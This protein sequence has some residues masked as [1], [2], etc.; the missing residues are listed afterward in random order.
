MKKCVIKRDNRRVIVTHKIKIKSRNQPLVPRLLNRLKKISSFGEKYAKIVKLGELILEIPHPGRFSKN[1]L[2]SRVS[3]IGD[4]TFLVNS[5][6]TTEHGI[7]TYTDYIDI[8]G[9]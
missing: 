7:C 4:E 9:C 8:V 1:L 3:K 2:H 5:L 6:L